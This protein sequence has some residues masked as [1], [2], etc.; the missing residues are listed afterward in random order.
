MSR[1][2]KSLAREGAPLCRRGADCREERPVAMHGV[3]EAIE[4]I[5]DQYKYLNNSATYD[6]VYQINAL[7]GMQAGIFLHI[8]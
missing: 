2:A 3:R 6:K 7:E 8:T 5:C 1:W 4:A